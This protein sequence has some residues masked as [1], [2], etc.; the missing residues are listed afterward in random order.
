MPFEMMPTE[1][2]FLAAPQKG[3]SFTQPDNG[4]MSSTQVR[5]RNLDKSIASSR[6]LTSYSS[7]DSRVCVAYA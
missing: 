3:Q 4:D 2:K 5:V 1:R 7:Q 6:R